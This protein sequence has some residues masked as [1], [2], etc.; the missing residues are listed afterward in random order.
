MA[1]EWHKKVPP[2]A[3]LH[4]ATYV[5]R[6]VPKLPGVGA[7]IA[8]ALIYIPDW[9][10]RL[11]FWIGPTISDDAIRQRLIAFLASPYLGL[12][13]IILGLAYL[14]WLSHR[15]MREPAPAAPAHH[16]THQI[17]MPIRELFEH[18]HPQPFS[19][20]AEKEEV[21]RAI[22]DHI[23]SDH[24]A[25]WGRRIDGSK[26]L[27]LEPIPYQN[28]ARAKLTYWFLA[29]DSEQALHLDCPIEGAGSAS[30]QY[31]D[32]RVN[33]DQAERIWSFVPLKDAARIVYERA[34]ESITAKA[35]EAEGKSPEG[36][37]L[38]FAQMIFAFG[39]VYAQRPPSTIR[40]L[41][42]VT[43]RGHM[44]VREDCASIGVTSDRYPTYT[45]V[46]VAGMDLEAFVGWANSGELFHIEAP[47]E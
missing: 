47:S 40:E 3:K 1:N 19:T 36:I 33:R 26:R 29:D 12:G 30:R 9:K 4:L 7:L 15:S 16:P 35:A 34:R 37:L 42:P 20:E 10:S 2:P 13:L 23:A 14:Y 32:L 31:A 11:D 41:V 17:G 45:H 38:W 43:V 18:I 8:G 28:F 46:V 44:R 25:A 22:I 24:M 27:A 21:G 6:F 5:R 39:T